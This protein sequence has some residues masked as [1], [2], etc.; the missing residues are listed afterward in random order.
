MQALK[1]VTLGVRPGEYVAIV[2]PSGSGKSTLLNVLGALDRPDAGEVFFNGEPLS[3]RKDLDR[4][5][6]R[7]IGFV[8]QSFYLLPSLTSRGERAGADVR[9]R[10]AVGPRP[11]QEG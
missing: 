5:R 1:D 9:G 6:A 11:R 8:F 10:A 3:A 2:G 7:Q 4:F